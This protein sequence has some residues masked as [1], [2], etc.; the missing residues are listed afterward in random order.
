MDN[1]P[2][3]GNPEIA[4]D[5]G[6][7]RLAAAQVSGPL[8]L[9]ALL[10]GWVHASSS[11]NS[12]PEWTPAV[13]YQPWFLDQVERDNIR[14]LVIRDTEIRGELRQPQ[15]YRPG[16]SKSAV[17]VSRFVTY[18]PSDQS[19]EPVITALRENS[20]SS[21]PVLIETRPASSDPGFIRLITALPD[22][23]DRGS[24]L[25]RLVASGASPAMTS[26]SVRVPSR[27]A[28]RRAPRMD[29]KAMPE[30]SVLHCT[31]VIMPWSSS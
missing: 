9:W 19:I 26:I 15:P 11:G 21:Q 29:G 22:D 16:P 27:L 10:H 28:D 20:R 13:D 6:K 5:Q 30:I 24:H 23:P 14:S 17:N 7:T 1:P 12:W 4:F 3:S 8:W 2:S 18:F 31:H 25:P